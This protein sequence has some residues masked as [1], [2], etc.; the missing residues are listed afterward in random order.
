MPENDFSDYDDDEYEDFDEDQRDLMH[1]IDNFDEDAYY[2]SRKP[3][4]PEEKEAFYKTEIGKMMK[5]YHEA[6]EKRMEYLREK[7]PNMTDEERIEQ[8]NEDQYMEQCEGEYIINL[9]EDVEDFCGGK[10]HVFSKEEM[11]DYFRNYEFDPHN[12]KYCRFYTLL[13]VVLNVPFDEI[14]KMSG[15]DAVSKL[16]EVVKNSETRQEEP[17]NRDDAFTEELPF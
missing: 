14:L 10:D 11:L 7:Y 16:E 5:E 3:M 1:M 17:V 6:H 2:A 8:D 13:A 9:Q 12:K 15:N 4:T